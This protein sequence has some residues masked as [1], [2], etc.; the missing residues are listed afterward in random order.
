MMMTNTIIVAKNPNVMKSGGFQVFTFKM[1][2]KNMLWLTQK[3]N[4]NGPAT[5]PATVKLTRVE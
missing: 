4:Q 5:D 3:A 2:G 1:D